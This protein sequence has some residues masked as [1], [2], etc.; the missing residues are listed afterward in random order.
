ML[1]F[2]ICLEGSHKSKIYCNLGMLINKL[3]QGNLDGWYCDSLVGVT[4]T[5]E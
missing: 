2:S 3:D 1:L 4:L 5:A